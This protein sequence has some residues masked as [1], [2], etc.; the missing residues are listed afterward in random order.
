MR[1]QDFVHVLMKNMSSNFTCANGTNCSRIRVDVAKKR[2]T[3]SQ[4]PHEHIVMVVSGK[5][6][7]NA[8]TESSEDEDNEVIPEDDKDWLENKTKYLF[9]HFKVDFSD[10]NVRTIEEKIMERNKSGDW[11]K[12]YQVRHHI[13]D[14]YFILFY[15]SVC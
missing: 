10:K 13:N 6:V 11:S 14:I 1:S 8:A 4:C 7:E 3:L 12:V 15:F 9:T 5:N 2:K